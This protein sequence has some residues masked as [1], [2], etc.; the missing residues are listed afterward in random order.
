MTTG[1]AITTTRVNV[2]Q[3]AA[4]TSAPVLRTL[5]TGTA[6][7][8][9]AQVNG[10]EVSGNDDWYQIEADAY[11]WSGGCGPLTFATTSSA[12]AATAPLV[13]DIYHGNSVTSFSQAYAAGLRGLIHKATTGESGTDSA[14]AQRRQDAAAAGL[15]WGAYHWGT[16]APIDAQVDN[17]L[18]FAKPDANTLVA[19]DYEQDTGGQMTLDGARQFLQGIEAKLG[20]KA[21]LYSG[22][23]IKS[24]LGSTKDAYFGSH[25]L[26]LAQ[27]GNTPSVQASWSTYW[28]WQYT[29]GTAGP[30]PRTCP[31]IPG[32]SAGNLDCDKF[33]GSEA[34]LKAQWAS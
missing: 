28:L 11:V 7:T 24:T 16:D 13:V 19:L 21:V 9:L 22:S 1:T 5:D 26:C 3:G 31:G 32:N 6:V 20:R 34:E 23:L 2:R 8:V 12:A 27:Y 15:L 33:Q 30:G 14:Y 4:S 18:N 10:D 17:F 25:R 29:D